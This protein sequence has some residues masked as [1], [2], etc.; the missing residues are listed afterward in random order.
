METSLGASGS[1]KRFLVQ[2]CYHDM[3]WQDMESFSDRN[4]AL[5]YAR[6]QSADAICVGMTR[7]IDKFHS[8]VIAV[9]PAGRK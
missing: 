3:D 4:K 9:N 1:P 2:N 5:E 8:V 6:E 7:V